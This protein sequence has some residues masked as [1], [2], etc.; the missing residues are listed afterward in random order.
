M[1]LKGRS[2]S[3]SIEEVQ[4]LITTGAAIARPDLKTIVTM[5]V[6]EVRYRQS[7]IAG[8]IA[9]DDDEGER[10]AQHLEQMLFGAEEVSMGNRLGIKIA[11]DAL[12]LLKQQPDLNDAA[13]SFAKAIA[14]FINEL[15]GGTGK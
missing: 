2:V 9:A 8:F 12:E 6:A 4:A 1:S 3:N 14:E 7:L 10:V 13:N 15:T 11:A 5:R